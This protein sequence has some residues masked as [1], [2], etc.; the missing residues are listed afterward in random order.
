MSKL[1]K[2]N[3]DY[4]KKKMEFIVKSINIIIKRLWHYKYV[5]CRI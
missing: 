4:Q 2:K 5:Y 1:I 3:D